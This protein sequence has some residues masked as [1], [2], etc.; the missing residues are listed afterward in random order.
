MTN[1]YFFAIRMRIKKLNPFIIFLVKYT[2]YMYCTLSTSGNN[3]CK[4]LLISFLSQVL[5]QN[6]MYTW[7]RKSYHSFHNHARKENYK[8]LVTYFPTC[9]RRIMSTYL[10]VN[11]QSCFTFNCCQIM[12]YRSFEE[13]KLVWTPKTPSSHTMAVKYQY[14]ILKMRWKQT[15]E[16]NE[17]TIL[18][19]CSLLKY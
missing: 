15:V 2:K 1:L 14:F 9:E 19:F 11:C 5:Q 7:S 17:F 18:L 12:N 13:A 10:P 8:L 6:L 4:L 3:H 16:L